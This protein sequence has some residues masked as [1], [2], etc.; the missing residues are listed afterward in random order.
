MGTVSFQLSAISLHLE[1][2]DAEWSS[3]VLEVGARLDEA[4]TI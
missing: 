2:E 1:G 4:P 3:K